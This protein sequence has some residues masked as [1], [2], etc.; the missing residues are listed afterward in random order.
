MP[1]T[2]C[3]SKTLNDSE[4]S[5]ACYANLF[6]DT[7]NYHQQTMRFVNSMQEALLPNCVTTTLVEFITKCG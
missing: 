7:A 5:L 4:H 6:S 3:F 1:N 2:S